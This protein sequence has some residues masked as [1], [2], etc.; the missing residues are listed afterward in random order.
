MNQT[1]K[2]RCPKTIK[3]REA[4]KLISVFV[5]QLDEAGELSEM[6]IP[7]LHRM[8]TA[9]DCYL[10]C[11]D[12]I[13]EKGMTVRNI[14]GEEVK[15]PEANLIRE[16]WNQYLEIAKEY[17][18]TKRSKSLLKIS[19]VNKEPETPAEKFFEKRNK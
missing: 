17:G 11:V 18:L 9:Y 12:V 5:R 6:D 16:N 10:T 14:K 19:N 13:H 7:Q 3:H 2:F 1:L 8:V 15:R 4:R